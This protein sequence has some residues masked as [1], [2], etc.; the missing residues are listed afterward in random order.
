[1]SN[2]IRRHSSGA[3]FNLSFTPISSATT[4]FTSPQETAHGSFTTSTLSLIAILQR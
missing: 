3:D 2:H 1:M 4:T